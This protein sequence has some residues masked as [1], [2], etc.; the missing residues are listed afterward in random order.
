MPKA[1]DHSEHVLH[2]Y[3]IRVS[4]RNKPT[5]KLKEQ[6]VGDG[7]RNPIPIRRQPLYQQLGYSDV[8]PITRQRLAGRFFPCRP[9]M[10]LLFRLSPGRSL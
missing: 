5:Q 4:G 7:I 3:T 8:L 1:R 9:R 2:Q 6:G 10:I